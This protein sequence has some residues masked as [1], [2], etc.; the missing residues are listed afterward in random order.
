MNNIEVLNFLT[1][2]TTNITMRIVDN[3]QSHIQ[4]SNKNTI[5]VINQ[6]RSDIK[7]I[8]ELLNESEY[9]LLL[10][11]D[12]RLA[13]LDNCVV[14][15]SDWLAIKSKVCSYVYSIEALPVLVGITGTNG[16]TSVAS[17]LSQLLEGSFSV[18]VMGTIGFYLNS[19]KVLEA[20]QTTPDIV[21]VYQFVSA[22]KPDVL[23][24]EVSSHALEQNRL[25][26][27]QL[28]YSAWTNFSQDHLDY[29][30]TM[31]EYFESKLKI[32][33]ITKHETLILENKVNL[34]K[35]VNEYN[36]FPEKVELLNATYPSGLDSFIDK[37]NISLAY[38]L[39]NKIKKIDVEQIVKLKSVPGRYNQYIL[40]NKSIAIVDFAHTP[41]ALEN[42]CKIAKSQSN[43]L[44]SKLYIVFGCGGDRDKKKRPLMG[45][46]ANKY[47][48][49]I[50]LTSDN[51]RSED[52]M[53]IIAD[54]KTAIDSDKLTVV[55]NRRN[56]ILKAASLAGTNDI[57]L[58][59]GK[60]HETDIDYNGVKSFHSDIKV[61]DELI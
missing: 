42:V 56:A 44:N 54:I 58:I 49:F 9:A 41:D 16:K 53:S 20:K 36:K 37:E 22:Y 21:D 23:V 39:A 28:A 17:F 2:S 33:N 8:L 3:V 6:I 35:K 38:A 34:L 47:A 13:S 10:T 24:F 31:K 18:G 11:A 12:D 48:D 40:K 57:I 30:K 59:A 46:I 5:L 26:D 60:G 27:V 61:V 51:P 50:I 45:G 29:H 1:L 15:S 43:D 55:E 52:P 14:V 25:S 7:K 32:F 19:K 4:E